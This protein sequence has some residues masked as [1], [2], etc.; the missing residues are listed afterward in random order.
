MSDVDIDY[1]KDA[2]PHEALSSKPGRPRSGGNGGGMRSKE[3][4][5]AYLAL[6][7]IAAHLIARFGLHAATKLY[8]LPLILVLT[9]GGAP[10]L[11]DLLR[12][13]MHRE[14]GSDLL[15]GLSIAAS[16]VLGE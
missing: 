5:I 14:F 10:L 3:S 2:A 12:R 8:D 1:T 6:L 9:I 7:G 16:A 11:F 13:I 15:A 4:Y